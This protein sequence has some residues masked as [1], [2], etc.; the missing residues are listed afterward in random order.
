MLDSWSGNLVLE[1]LSWGKEEGK[2]SPLRRQYDVGCGGDDRRSNHTVHTAE[3]KICALVWTMELGTIMDS[4][5]HCWEVR[6][7]LPSP[8]IALQPLMLFCCS[9]LLD[10]GV[11]KAK[12]PLSHAQRIRT[13]NK[14]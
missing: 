12:D 8:T 2:R 1:L 9:L 11:P 10:G 5:S 6:G 13:L 3:A 7:D 14:S 4:C